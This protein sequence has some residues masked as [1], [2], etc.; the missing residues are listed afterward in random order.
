MFVIPQILIQ[1]IRTAV[2]SQLSVIS[3]NQLA[4]DHYFCFFYQL[5][6]RFAGALLLHQRFADQERFVARGEQTSYVSAGLDA[7]LGYADA[8]GG[9]FFHE[10]ECSFE[11]DF[12]G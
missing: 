12:E 8:R 1:V 3:K 7:A 5:C 10:P 6:Q 11:I 9:H 4:T 2:S